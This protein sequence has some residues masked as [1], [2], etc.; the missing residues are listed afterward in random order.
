MLSFADRLPFRDGIPSAL[1][2]QLE[3]TL[4]IC[5]FLFPCEL[6]ASPPCFTSYL[7]LV[8][9]VAEYTGD[10]THVDKG[11]QGLARGR[12][13]VLVA[14][15]IEFYGVLIIVVW[16]GASNISARG[17]RIPRGNDNVLLGGCSAR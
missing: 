8:G 14:V 2:A 16:S 17:S 5:Q 7:V 9:K 11:D 6:D 12:P 15:G 3:F 10:Q 4:H 13:P 1:S